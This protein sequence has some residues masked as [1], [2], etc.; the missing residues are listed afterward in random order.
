MVSYKGFIEYLL[1][2]KSISGKHS[3]NTRRF[4]ATKLKQGLLNLIESET[5]IRIITER[6]HF[7]NIA[8]MKIGRFSWLSFFKSVNK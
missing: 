4:V 1:S 3:L 6:N 7:I 2:S 5:K 8:I